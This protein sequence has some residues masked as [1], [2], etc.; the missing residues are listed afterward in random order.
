MLPAVLVTLM[1]PAVPPAPV[2]VAAPVPAVSVAVV[3]LPAVLFE[4]VID[5]QT[6]EALADVEVLEGECAAVLGREA[7]A[8]THFV[9]ALDELV[10]AYL[11]LR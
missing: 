9:W 4:I 3:T 7:L 6:L 10:A 1:L 5:P 8:Q 11:A 2:P